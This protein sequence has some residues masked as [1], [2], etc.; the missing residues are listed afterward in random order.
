MKKEWEKQ[1]D[2]L[3]EAYHPEMIEK[4]RELIR[5]KS[6]YGPAEENAP[7]GVGPRQAFDFAM[8]L[9]EEKE[10]ECVNFDYRAGEI[11]FG[12]GEEAAGVI[13]HMDVVPEGDGWTH[14][15]YGGEIEDGVIY[16]RGAVDDKGC[17]IAAFYACLALKES[18]VPLKRQIKHI[19]GTNEELGDFPCICYYKDHVEKMPVCGIVPDA[20]FPAVFAEKGFLNFSFVKNLSVEETD[21]R[22]PVLTHFTGG[23][24]LNVV[25]PKAE[26]VF[27]GSAE[28]LG[29]I[30]RAAESLLENSG[31]S[32][33][34]TGNRL[35][36]TIE[37]KSAHASSPEIGVNAG[38]LMLQVLRDIDFYP[39]SLCR[40]LHRL[41]E[42]IAF[43]T[44]GSGLGIS[45]EDASGALTNNLGI[46]RLDENS[47]SAG[48]NIRYPVSQQVEELE[49]KLGKAAEDA[50][51]ECQ[52]LMRNPHFYVDPDGSLIKRLVKIY[53]EMTGDAE[54]KLIA[55]GSGSYAR[56]LENFIPYGPSIPGEE[57]CFHKQDEH[58]SCERLLMLSRIYA[59]ALYVMATEDLVEE[60]K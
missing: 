16:G 54:S 17:F 45:F 27:E 34:E 28:Q 25:M 6:V 52:I 56:I 38:A 3:L 31:F 33:S 55:H 32:L 39:E 5:I 21:S 30:R 36:L 47:F 8:R 15:P 22:L 7:F 1:I 29:K 59:R 9:G 19:I 13:S 2:S 57:L 24:A 20:R 12:Q 41:A 26:A 37:G 50:G 60:S 11:N 44:D 10:F 18:G 49:K 23:E 40:S 14:D 43:D 51:C 4:L 42:Q 48:M 46:I 35:T 53:Q 58:I